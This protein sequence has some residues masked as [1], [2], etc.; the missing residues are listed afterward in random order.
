MSKNNIHR[1]LFYLT[2]EIVNEAVSLGHDCVKINL[3]GYERSQLS[4]RDMKKYI[5]YW[6][7]KGWM[8]Q[9]LVRFSDDMCD[10]IVLRKEK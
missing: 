6:A 5:K 2:K 1:K 8:Y 7:K 10:P 3:S 4:D 9:D